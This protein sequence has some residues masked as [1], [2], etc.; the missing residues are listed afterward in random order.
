MGRA[1]LTDGADLADSLGMRIVDD[2][3]NPIV[4]RRVGRPTVRLPIRWV[5]P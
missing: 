3:G 4:T 5:F 1:Q 2:A